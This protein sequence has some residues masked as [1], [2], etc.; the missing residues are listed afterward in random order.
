M[1]VERL[2]RRGVR[3]ITPYI[4]GKPIEEVKR[5]RCLRRVVKLA[6]NEN[7]LGPSPKAVAAMRKVLW[8]MHRYPDGGGQYLRRRLAVHHGLTP[9]HFVLGNGSDEIITLA[10]RTFANE[11]DQVVVAKPTFLIYELAARLAHADVVTVPL[12]YDLKYDLRAMR[13]AITARTKLV[14]IA[15]P[16]NPTGSYVSDASV[17]EFFKDLP[18]HVVV[19]CDEAY[20]EYV[21]AQDFPDVTQ[22]MATHNVVVLRTFSKAYGLA[23]CRVGYG[24]GRPDLMAWIERSREPFN[25][26]TLAQVAAL[27]ALDDQQHLRNTQTMIWEQKTYL[28]TQCATL[29]VRPIPSETNFVLI[30]VG[31][32]APHVVD[33]LLDYGVIVRDMRAWGLQRYVRVTIG[34]AKE[35]KVCIK[36]LKRV[37]KKLPSERD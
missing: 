19:V 37:L 32:R 2:T 20:R 16:D 25:V 23:G 6:S 7:A 28:M 13:A 12:T 17:A 15:N 1:D 36:A 26:N 4:P 29:G 9:E 24:F 30:D 35:N 22:Y 8:E 31:P 14:F 34:T 33:R 27:A 18:S 21:E 3:D 5:D 10:L 11:G